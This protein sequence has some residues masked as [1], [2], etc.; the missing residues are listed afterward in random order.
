MGAGVAALFFLTSSPAQAAWCANF[1]LGGDNC[2]FS[3][4]EACLATIRGVG[5]TCTQSREAAGPTEATPKANRR[6]K[7]GAKPATPT[8]GR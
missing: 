1:P 3:S 8:S 5:G 4:F 7:P 6:A 2:G